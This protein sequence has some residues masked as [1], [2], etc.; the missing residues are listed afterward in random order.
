MTFRRLQAG[1]K[2]I[3]NMVE[4]FGETLQA[5]RTMDTKVHVLVSINK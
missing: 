4:P 3:L 2:V 1:K 5:R